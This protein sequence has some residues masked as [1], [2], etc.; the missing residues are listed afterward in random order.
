MIG[1]QQVAFV[2]RQA[3]DLLRP[4]VEKHL[5]R[6]RRHNVQ[7]TIAGLVSRY[8]RFNHAHRVFSWSAA[9]VACAV[10]VIVSKDSA[11]L[12]VSFNSSRPINRIIASIWISAHRTLADVFSYL[13]AIT[14]GIQ[15]RD[16][17]A[18]VRSQPVAYVK[19]NSA[20]RLF[21][22][23]FATGRRGGIPGELLCRESFHAR[24]RENARQRCRKTKTVR[25][26]ILGACLAKL[27]LEKPVA[28]KDLSKDR[29]RGRNIDVALFHRRARGKPATRGNILLHA[30]V[31]GRPVF[32]H[33]AITV[34]AAEV[35]DIIRILLKQREVVVHRLRDVV[36]DDAWILPTPLR[37]EMCVSNDVEGRLFGEIRLRGLRFRDNGDCKRNC[38][39]KSEM[40]RF[41]V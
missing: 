31:I 20:R 25:Q 5:F 22:R 36:V 27:A 11:D 4:N 6:R 38:E 35:E 13:T 41:H 18:T 39:Y 9:R 26:H 2:T 21:D 1:Q 24:V 40:L 17:A 23:T 14:A 29:F 3:F 32:L 12:T 7:W 10:I 37:V 30:R 15:R 19:W 33:H 8:Y 34:R 28:I 16:N